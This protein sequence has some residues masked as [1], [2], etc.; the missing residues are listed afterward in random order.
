MTIAELVRTRLSHQRVSGQKSRNAGEVVRWMG[1]VQAQ[2]YASAL[3]AIGV[4]TGNATQVSIERAIADR[5]IVRTWPMRGTSHFVSPSDVRWMLAY[6]TPRIVARAAFRFKQL[7]LDEETF[8]R[9][10][11]I[12][13]KTLGDRKFLTR[14]EVYALLEKNR[15]SCK[16]QRGIHILWRLA[17]DGVVCC[18]PRDGKQQTFVL[19]DEWVPSQKKNLRDEALANF[20]ERYFNSHGPATEKDFAWWTGLTIGEARTI[21][22]AAKSHLHAVTLGGQTYWSG[23]Q[24]RYLVARETAYLL[25]SF[26]EFL[27]GYTD[28]TALVDRRFAKRMHPGGGI[29]SA[30]IILNGRVIGTWSRSAKK[31]SIQIRLQT[32]QSVNTK[33]RSLIEQAAAGYGRF[34]GKRSNIIS[35]K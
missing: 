12:I 6:L 19:L 16:G 23:N 22:E 2:D 30:T 27:V 13:E 11:S 24:P 10:G 34:T 7:E 26:D 21:L 25:P 15:I 14:D 9:S 17:Q 1:A 29:L 32:F 35:L 33:T 31:D 28:R 4:R 5:K 18:G 8:R 3:W 20:A